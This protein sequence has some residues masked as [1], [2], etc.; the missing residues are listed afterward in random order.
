[1]KRLSRRGDPSP[2]SRS[3]SLRAIHPLPQREREESM[4]LRYSISHATSPARSRRRLVVG[5]WQAPVADD[6]AGLVALAGDA[7]HI[8]RPS[9]AMRRGSPR[10]GRRSR[11]RPALRREWRR[12]WRPA[13]RSLSSVTMTM[14]A[15][16]SAARPISG[17][18]PGS[19]SPPA[20]KTT[21]SR[22]LASGGAPRALERVGLVGVVD[23]DH[24]AILVA[25][26]LEPPRAPWS[27][28]S[29][30]TRAPA[31]TPVAMARPAA[32]ARSAPGRRRRAAA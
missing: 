30:A 8:A 11:S 25:D 9:M 21:M 16:A 22:P 6:L 27:V 10:R 13:V 31:A 28:A 23:E 18:L 14:S 15:F 26:Q 4:L 20:P 3:L 7:E 1:M 24:R 2:G 29:A 12:G 19:R 32:T 5:E 17:R